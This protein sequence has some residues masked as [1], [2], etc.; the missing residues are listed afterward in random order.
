MLPTKFKGLKVIETARVLART[1]SLRCYQGWE[2]H[3]RESKATQV[4]AIESIGRCFPPEF[5][6]LNVTKT[7]RVPA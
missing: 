3:P 6:G 5:K 4:Q 1:E 2:H 7:A